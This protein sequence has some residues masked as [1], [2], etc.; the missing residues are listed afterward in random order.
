MKQQDRIIYYRLLAAELVVDKVSAAEANKL[1]RAYDTAIAQIMASLKTAA[2]WD[3]NRLIALLNIVILQQE[4][5]V[6]RF[7]EDILDTSAEIA[8]FQ[9]EKTASALSFNEAVEIASFSKLT[10]EQI[11]SL[12]A[13]KKFGGKT[14]EEWV[15]N[16][17]S[18]P[19]EDFQE[20]VMA[21]MIQ[22][23]ALDLTADQIAG[24]VK[25]ITEKIRRDIY[26]LVRSYS[27]ASGT[28]AR[29]KVYDANRGM[30]EQ[31]EWTATLE[32]GSRSGA[33]T[34]IRCMAL[35]GQKWDKRGDAPTIPLH[36]NCRCVLVPITKDIDIPGF[37]W[38]KEE[39]EARK[40]LEEEYGEARP[41]KNR[42]GIP[43]YVK[44]NKKYSAWFADHKSGWQDRA[45]GPVRGK[46]LRSGKIKFK[47]LIKKNGDLKTLE[48]LGFDNQGNKL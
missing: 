37:N 7:S 41:T 27:L 25:G 35:D 10:K 11:L 47:D 8:K 38:A 3:K 31:Y 1:V 19:W 16:T 9:F 43:D 14:I 42:T 46:L 26:T 24:E 4:A 48:E 13:D 44:S 17:L 21:G 18:T 32:A 6:K 34:C 2:G 22:G 40:E 23:R 28:A 45:V 39:A 33:G 30:I 5:L 20:A 15:R 29:H 12:F 36:M